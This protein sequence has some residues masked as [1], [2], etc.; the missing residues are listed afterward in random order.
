MP[1]SDFAQKKVL[2][3]AL[4][5]CGGLINAFFTISLYANL[6]LH[7]GGVTSVLAIYLVGARLTLVHTILIGIPLAFAMGNNFIPILV[8]LEISFLIF[9]TRY[10]WS[11]VY[12]DIVF[13]LFIGM[14]LTYFV[15]TSG[16]PL[17]SDFTFTTVT[18]QAINGLLYVSIASVILPLIPRK[19]NVQA[20]NRDL[21]KLRQLIQTK[22]ET[23]I[24]GISILVGLVAAQNSVRIHEETLNKALQ[25]QSE[26][27]ALYTENMLESHKKVI[28]ELSRVI[29]ELGLTF[30]QQKQAIQISQHNNDNF[31]SM[32]IA[33][34]NGAVTMAAPEAFHQTLLGGNKEMSVSDRDYFIEAFENR[35]LY[36]SDVFL[37]RG[38][39]NDIIIAI[40]AP[41]YPEQKLN[42]VQHPAQPIGIVEGSLNL[43]QLGSME[44]K[45]ALSEGVKVVL[46][47]AKNRV[48]H[49]SE[50]LGLNALEGFA[51][52]EPDDFYHTQIPVGDVVSVSDSGQELK[53]LTFYQSHQL[54]NGWTA[55]IL[56]S[57]GVLLK[58]FEQYYVLILAIAIGLS[59]VSFFI[60][61][62]IGKI[63]AN[64]LELITAHFRKDI[65]EQNLTVDQM[66]VNAKEYWELA[67]SLEENQRL[68]YQ[69]QTKLVEQVGDKTKQLR[70][71]NIELSN[72]RFAAEEASRLKS[73]FLANMSHEIRT[74]MNG[75]LGILELLS[76][77][78]ISTEQSHRLDL[79]ISSANSLLILINDI[80]DLSKIESGKLEIESYAF[81][82]EQ[83][84][85]DIIKSSNI[86][87]NNNGNQITLDVSSLN[88][89]YLKGD[90]LRLRQVIVNLMSNAVK[91]THQGKIC[92][93][94]STKLENDQIILVC[95]VTD[96]GIGIQ[97]EKVDSLFSAFSQAD[98]STTRE[99]GGTGL[100]LTISKQICQLMQGDLEVESEVGK[101]SRF[102]LTANFA[103][104]SD[105][106]IRELE[107][108]KGDSKLDFLKHRLSK[109][110]GAILAV[111]DNP[112][113][114]E[115]IS[116]LLDELQLT[117]RIVENGKEAIDSIRQ[118]GIRERYSI[119]LMDCQMP[120]MDGYETTRRIRAG[121]AGEVFRSIPIVAMTAN[122]MSGDREKCLASGMSDYLSKPI[123]SN[124]FAEKLA[125]WLGSENVAANHQSLSDKA[126][127]AESS[128][129]S[130]INAGSDTGTVL[131]APNISDSSAEKLLNI[132][133]KQA[134]LSRMLNKEKI[135]KVAV[136]S[137]LDES[138]KYKA[139]LNDALGRQALSD[140]Q[141]IAH[142]IKG[143]AGNI[144]GE[145]LSKLAA[146]LEF[147]I[148]QGNSNFS[149]DSEL[150]NAKVE[151]IDKQ[152]DKLY[153]CLKDYLESV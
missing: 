101:G 148:K 70:E 24:I 106:D 95:S 141:A 89:Q 72:A 88:H 28:N 104:A 126:S 20:S 85:Q 4:V 12:A 21:P 84:L 114:R 134:A 111:E 67:K 38:F 123:D 150:I 45:I 6:M 32:L 81:D 117:Y 22:L 98:S 142:S 19:R 39:G 23:I 82:L 33:D 78:N 143:S 151:D 31:I 10:R 121:D 5:L 40:S 116:G 139:K 131:Q 136:A 99:Y 59:L 47:D 145:L 100:G 56:Q 102:T 108:E 53:A 109:V 17:N 1:S 54:S 107:L 135:L 77:S 8:F 11:V 65:S 60:S 46:L 129:P 51:L 76:R 48:I 125:Y 127:I 146:D 79:A 133:N 120:V 105:K 80:L 144:G 25:W 86:D 2:F 35:M 93:A 63:I 34:S 7:L 52:K 30:E 132:F 43:K 137:F 97:Q 42:E 149:D 57:P 75:V 71:A 91:F 87:A 140:V 61:R 18:K 50:S 96:T 103:I 73:Q 113:N 112:V 15:F 37:G 124:L 69:F 138:L 119:V 13:W 90:P 92:L 16:N 36:V 44:Q 83:L 14:P 74:P 122:A 64:P 27:A 66:E 94:A 130:K 68:Q 110:D 152:I 49:S 55:Y 3:I 26:E 41:I 62:H 115:V 9:L 128:E 147:S 29:S 118:F 153:E 58:E